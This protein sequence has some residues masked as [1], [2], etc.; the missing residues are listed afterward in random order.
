MYVPRIGLEKD[1]I[2]LWT[3]QTKNGQIICK[4][5]VSRDASWDK[6]YTCW[7]MIHKVI[8]DLLSTLFKYRPTLKYLINVHA[9][10]FHH[11][12]SYCTVELSSNWKSQNLFLWVQIH[13]RISATTLKYLINVHARFQKI[14]YFTTLHALIRSCT[15]YGYL[16]RC[17]PALLLHP[18]HFDA[19]FWRSVHSKFCK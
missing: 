14:D 6:W 8:L 10:F 2:Y 19:F 4:D 5:Q 18:A 7:N 1:V 9:H 17:R 13:F 11:A 3:L 16:E 15:F 12:H